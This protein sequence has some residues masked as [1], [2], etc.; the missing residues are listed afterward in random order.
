MSLTPTEWNLLDISFPFLWLNF[1]IILRYFNGLIQ[2]FDS[3][4]IKYWL[5]FLHKLLKTKDVI[6]W[7]LLM[8]FVIL[9]VYF[10]FCSISILSSS[11]HL[12]LLNYSTKFP[13]FIYNRYFIL[14]LP[15]FNVFLIL[16][17]D[18]RINDSLFPSI[19]H[20]LF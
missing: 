10:S 12:W 16:F 18:I 14:I 6:F 17:K 1:L 7:W 19:I 13:T 20:I 4:F 15:C 8:N 5:A 3:F 11:R 9:R 2:F